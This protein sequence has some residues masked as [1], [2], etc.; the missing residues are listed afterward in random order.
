VDATDATELIESMNAAVRHARAP[1][2]HT[3]VI[4]ERR[5]HRVRPKSGRRRGSCPG[6]PASL[7]S[8][9]AGSSSRRPR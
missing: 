1:A 3:D 9:L 8:P 2:A 7:A 5:E 6:A 4:A